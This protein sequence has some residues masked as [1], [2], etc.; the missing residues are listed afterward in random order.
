MELLRN[1]L[2]MFVRALYNGL[3]GSFGEPE[4]ISF[5][6]ISI[7]LATIIL[8]L[9]MLP[10]SFSQIKNQK[11]MA[12][13]QPEIQKLQQK[14]K[15]DPQTLA[16]KQQKLYKESNYSMLGGCLP[17]IVTLI[18]LIAFYRVFMYPAKYIFTEPGLY[19]SIQKNFFYIPNIDNPDK[20]VFMPLLA[21]ITTFLSSYLT[22]KTQPQPEQGGGM[23]NTMM[24]VMPLLIFYMGRNFATALVLYWIVSNVFQL[25]QQYITN[26]VVEKV[27]EEENVLDK[28]R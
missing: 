22:Q 8:K 16:Q 23:M 17:M 20:T 14:Y 26:K 1:L 18:V 25:V 10:L 13:L 19:D 2:G 6:A 11:K 12:E 9:A 4:S 24:I 15:N 7:I 3:H 21:G 27:K 5:F 28:N